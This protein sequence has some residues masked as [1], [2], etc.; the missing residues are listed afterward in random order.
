M[1]I[2]Q[3]PLTFEQVNEVNKAY[4]SHVDALL[5]PLG[6][7]LNKERTKV[8]LDDTEVGTYDR[9]ARA[10]RFT[11][12]VNVAGQRIPGGSLVDLAGVAAIVNGTTRDEVIKH[13]YKSRLDAKVREEV[14]R[15]DAIEEARRYRATRDAE[16]YATGNVVEPSFVTMS[17]IRS[18]ERAPLEYRIEGLLMKGARTLI[19]GGPKSG[20]STVTRD[21]I[22]ALTTERPA[23]GAFNVLPTQG[24]VVLLDFELVRDDLFEELAAHSIA[25]DKFLAMSLRDAPRTYFD[26]FDDDNRMEWAKRLSDVGTETLVVDCLGPVIRRLNRDPDREGAATIEAIG[27]LCAEAGITDLIV[28]DHTSAKDPDGAKG[29]RGDSQKLDTV[30]HYLFLKETETGSTERTVKGRGRKGSIDLRLDFNPATARYTVV[31]G[32]PVKEQHE[33]D[34]ADLKEYALQAVEYLHAEAVEAG[35]NPEDVTAYPFQSAVANEARAR[36]MVDN[37]EISIKRTKDAVAHLI[38]RGV[39]KTKPGKRKSDR[40]VLPGD[41]LYG[42]YMSKQQSA[43]VVAERQGVAEVVSLFQ[44]GT[45]DDS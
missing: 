30:D 17:E 10:I 13:F 40:H 16:K 23:F 35:V 12:A 28:L 8:A 27:S 41:G 36:Y 32:A 19:Y 5:V 44:R 31:S 20:K 4:S 33:V 11:K 29:P 34:A 15:Q 39:L 1:S 38:Q 45:P 43:Y 6:L 7:T 2:A 14:A 24:R 9:R 26:P 25:E 21:L 22:A 37:R 18:T 42:P 3:Q